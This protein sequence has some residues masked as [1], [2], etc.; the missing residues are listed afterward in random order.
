MCD[1]LLPLAAAQAGRD[2]FAH[3]FHWYPGDLPDTVRRGLVRLGVAGT[4]EQPLCHGYGQGLLGW[5]L[6][7]EFNASP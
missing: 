6:T 5:I 3:W 4:R 1:G 2:L 7:R